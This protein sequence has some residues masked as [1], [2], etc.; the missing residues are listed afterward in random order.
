MN[1]VESD[2]SGSKATE[3]VGHTVNIFSPH[4]Y[5]FWPWKPHTKA[6]LHI[7]SDTDTLPVIY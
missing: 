5:I 7:L 1:G 4:G 2:S 3:A 6:N